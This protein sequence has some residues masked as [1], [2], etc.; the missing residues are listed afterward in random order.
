MKAPWSTSTRG[1]FRK[2]HTVGEQGDGAGLGETRG[3]KQLPLGTPDLKILK[4]NKKLHNYK[5]RPI[6]TNYYWYRK[7]RNRA[8][9][10]IRQ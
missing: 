10:D 7:S 4:K 9:L 3:H 5:S 1:R 2:I 6:F 8:C